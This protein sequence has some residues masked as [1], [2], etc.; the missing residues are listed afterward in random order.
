MNKGGVGG[1]KSAKIRC[2]SFKKLRWDQPMVKP[3]N[4]PRD[5]LE[6]ER[7]IVLNR[8]GRVD[9][10]GLRRQAE[11]LGHA[12]R[13]RDR[14]LIIAGRGVRYREVGHA[15]DLASPKRRFSDLLEIN[16][17]TGSC[18]GGIRRW[19]TILAGPDEPVADDKA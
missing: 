18:L 4:L 10:R 11:M 3:I 7:P 5:T 12:G 13:D 6:I 17:E 15:Q 19:A 8:I 9:V 2:H 1:Q 16:D 14:S